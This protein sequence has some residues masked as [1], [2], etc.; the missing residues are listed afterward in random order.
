MLSAAD[1]R[2]W[3]AKNTKVGNVTS[4]AADKRLLAVEFLQRWR[5]VSP[6]KA[7]QRHVR[8]TVWVS[9]LGAQSNAVKEKS[10]IF[11]KDMAIASL[12]MPARPMRTVA[13]SRT[14]ARPV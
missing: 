3:A 6:S 1:T 14:K 8:S 4:F 10:V 9:A 13:S 11:Y 7:I 12:L 5:P 2:L